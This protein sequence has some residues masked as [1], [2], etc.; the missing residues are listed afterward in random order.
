MSAKPRTPLTES[1]RR[2][3][4]ETS[5]RARQALHDFE[6]TGQPVTYAKIATAAA[7]S[8]AW[9]YTQ[10]DIRAAI[11]RLRDLNGRST[12]HPYPPGSEAP[13]AP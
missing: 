13:K 6:T 9:L 8:R 2:R 5:G 1:A 11:D 10:P 4:Q 7:V 12:P 3:H